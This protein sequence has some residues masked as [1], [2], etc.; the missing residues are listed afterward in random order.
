MPPTYLGSKQ[1]MFQV[2]TRMSL[3][4]EINYNQR[5]VSIMFT[6]TEAILQLQIL[7]SWYLGGKEGTFQVPKC[8]SLARGINCN[9]R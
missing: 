4:R 2:P 9:Q 5:W 7:F 6:D 1:G 3:G 8:T